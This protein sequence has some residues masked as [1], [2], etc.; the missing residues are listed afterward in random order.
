[1]RKSSILYAAL[2]AA[3][4]FVHASAQQDSVAIAGTE[5]LGSKFTVK[6]N[7][8]K[9]RN[10][11]GKVIVRVAHNFGGTCFGVRLGIKAD[12]LFSYGSKDT[13]LVAAR[14]TD[15]LEAHDY[16]FTT[17]GSLVMKIYRDNVL[18]GSV[19]ESL[20]T[21]YPGGAIFL[22]ENAAEGYTT[23][24]N[25]A[26]EETITDRDGETNT[27]HML[28]STLTNLV[29]DPFFNR[30]F[31]YE[32]PNSADREGLYT[33]QA[34]Y[35]GWGPAAYI[36]TEAFS[37]KACARIEGRAIYDTQGASLDVTLSMKENTPYLVRAM[38]KSDGYEGK[39]GIDKCNSYI[40]I[41]DTNNEWKQV[42]AVLTPTEAS[43]LLFV[44]NTDFDSNGTLW[45]DNLEVYQGYT[46]ATSARSRTEIPCIM[47]D[48]GTNFATRRVSNVYML[49]LAD[50]GEQCATVDTS[51]V[52]VAGGMMLKKSYTGSALYAIHFPGELIQAT[53]TGYYDGFSHTDEQLRHGLDFAV[54]KYDAPRFHYLSSDAPLTA[55]D[56]M[57]QFVDNLEDV[58]I[59][60]TFNGQKNGTP[61]SGTYRMEGNPYATNHTPEGKFLKYDVDAQRFVLTEGESLK[62]FEAYIATDETNPVAQIVPSV[63]TTSISKT[64][65]DEG[66]AISVRNM[67]G[68]I[69]IYATEAGRIS[70]HG[71]DGRILRTVDLREGDNQ[72]PMSRGIY[73][74][75]R[76]KVAV[77]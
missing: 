66:S 72:V 52:K 27:T 32:G 36:D 33:Q 23:E 19:D 44:N 17:D 5:A 8:L 9:L 74:V 71:I 6:V 7:N 41:S 13:V 77:H 75:G 20:V 35:G 53:A 70:I 63:S 57:I 1:M 26:E 62:P 30:G 14:L 56:Y 46:S 54:I 28:P 64:V 18:F 42:E 24:V 61:A 4:P 3:C 69:V 34:I 2:L 29:G 11:D 31:T 25:A 76:K 65:S 67:T 68:G 39:I 38:V 55:G 12:S 43:T 16:A 73:I 51:L 50:D 59:T 21:T 40:H 45:I 47:I 48:A 49:G 15:G 22:A 60:L 10:A 37:G 58:D